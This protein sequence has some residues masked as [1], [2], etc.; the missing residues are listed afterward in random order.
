MKKL[1][2]LCLFICTVNLFYAEEVYSQEENKTVPIIYEKDGCLCVADAMNTDKKSVIIH[3]SY[4]EMET[5]IILC[6]PN[7]TPEIG[8]AHV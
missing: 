8:R 7:I 3:G 6:K 4:E 2:A 5:D 1:M